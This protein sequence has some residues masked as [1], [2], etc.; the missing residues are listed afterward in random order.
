MHALLTRA[1]RVSALA[2]IEDNIDQ[3]VDEIFG[4]L[5]V[6]K[7]LAEIFVIGYF[8]IL[9]TIFHAKSF[10]SSGGLFQF[11]VYCIVNRA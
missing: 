9:V 4:F 1:A 3:L 8:Y 5:P 7:E 2:I 11:S 10:S 6:G